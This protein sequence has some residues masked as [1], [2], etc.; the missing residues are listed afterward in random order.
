MSDW[1]LST[2]VNIVPASPPHSWTEGCLGPEQQSHGQQNSDTF[3][4]KK[5]SLCYK[6]WC[7]ISILEDV[8]L[9]PGL[10]QSV[11]GLALQEAAA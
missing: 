10:P 7:V 11:K 9:I 2:E 8:G 6:I 5:S 3:L 1:T 4:Q